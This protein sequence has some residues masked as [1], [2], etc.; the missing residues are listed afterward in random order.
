MFIVMI[1][2]SN[3]DP[4][5]RLGIIW[6]AL[7]NEIVFVDVAATFMVQDELPLDSDIDSTREQC[8]LVIDDISFLVSRGAE[9]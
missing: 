9:A 2:F 6:L 1:E 4:P 5:N 3:F 7:G 8:L